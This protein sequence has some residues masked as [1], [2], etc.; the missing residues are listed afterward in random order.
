M[1]DEPQK[2]RV[3]TQIAKETCNLSFKKYKKR[4][5]Q[6][7]ERNLI[8]KRH[9][10]SKQYLDMLNQGYRIISF[11]E[12]SFD[13]FL[14]AGKSWSKRGKTLNRSTTA[15]GKRISVVSAIDNYG[16]AYVSFV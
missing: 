11:D 4:L 10:Y 9:Y 5:E 13:G 14:Y 7:D 12:A 1:E 8:L 16:N 15:I 3:I 2:R 6:A